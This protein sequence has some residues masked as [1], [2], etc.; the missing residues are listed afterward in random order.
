MRV[1]QPC[2]GVVFEWHALQVHDLSARLLEYALSG[3]RVPLA[4]RAEP[5]IHVRAALGKQA[6]LQ[7]TP[8]LD[9]LMRS[10]PSEEQVQ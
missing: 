2:A 6:E 7:R 8:D 3:S 5:R 4:G 10:E 1:H 9:Q